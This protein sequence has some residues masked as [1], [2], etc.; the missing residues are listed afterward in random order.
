MATPSPTPPV[1]LAAP[2][3]PDSPDSPVREPGSSGGMTPATPA[4]DP[5]PG[6]AT[7]KMQED[8]SALALPHERDQ[9]SDMT[10]ARPDPQVQQAGREL[11]RG[12]QDTGKSTPMD[13][14]YKQL[15]R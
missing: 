9:S 15:K 13:N 6:E 8:A 1:T 10:D 3:N 2:A 4:N 12:L 5:V 7:D 14:T 11:K